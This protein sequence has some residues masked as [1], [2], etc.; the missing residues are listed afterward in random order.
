MTKPK[1]AIVKQYVKLFEL[2]FGES[3]L[4]LF[5]CEVQFSPFIDAALTY[6]RFTERYFNLKDGLY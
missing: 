3:S 4:K 2:D 5:N 6:N 1:N